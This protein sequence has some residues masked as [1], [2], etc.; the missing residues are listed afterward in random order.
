[1]KLGPVVQEEMLFKDIPYLEFWQPLWTETICAILEEGIMRNNPVK[2][3][4]YR[5]MV[6]EEMRFKCI[7]YLKLWQPFC[8]SVCNIG[9]GYYEEQF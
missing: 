2:Y 5:P 7:S 4:E 8:N 6:Q 1:M 9:R 3:F